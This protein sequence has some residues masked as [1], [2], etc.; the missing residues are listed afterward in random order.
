[1]R[2]ELKD[3]RVEIAGHLA[4]ESVS[5]VLPDGQLGCLLGP[6]GSDKTSL[7]RAIAGFVAPVRGEI[8]VGERCV[9]QPG[10]QLAPERRGIGMVFQDL[11]LL[12]HLSVRDNVGFG[13]WQWSE[14]KRRDRVRELLSLAGLGRLADRYPH[15][16]S[17]GQQQRVAVARALAPRPRL[18]LMD[19]PFS[20]LD[21]EQ[22]LIMAQQM[23]DL[24]IGTGT[25]TLM[26]THD[27]REA[28][29]IGDLIGVLNQGRLHQWASPQAVHDRPATRFV[30]G[31]VGDGVL[32]PASVDDSGRLQTELGDIAAPEGAAVGA[33][34]LLV[35]PPCLRFDPRSP[36]EGVI[37]QCLYRGADT[38]YRVCLASGRYVVVIGSDQA[39]AV[40]D[41]VGVRLL[42]HA[43]VLFAAD[44]EPRTAS[45]GPAA[46]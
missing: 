43:P 14:A 33:V 11:A 20:G 32:L 23:R 2:L 44:S 41:T 34:S 37:D 46:A 17:G 16:L 24:V 26:V 18:L 13:L 8:R 12:P 39:H 1:M 36:V 6:S 4:C 21:A 22:R 27:Q 10:R 7:L 28:L 31:F 35:R 29:A 30:A 42:A 38:L 9:A 25:T 40:G 45:E 15:E 19:E 3:L 5:L